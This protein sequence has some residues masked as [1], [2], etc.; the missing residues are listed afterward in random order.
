MSRLDIAVISWEALSMQQVHKDID[1]SQ[2]HL[3]WTG[4][5]RVGVKLPA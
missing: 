2:W 5:K 3:R 1:A 4:I